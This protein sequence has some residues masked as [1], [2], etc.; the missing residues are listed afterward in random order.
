M[1]ERD[2]VVFAADGFDLICESDCVNELAVSRIA[3][4]PGESRR[5]SH[6]GI[7]IRTTSSPAEY[8][9]AASKISRPSPHGEFALLL[10]P[11]EFKGLVEQRGQGQEFP[12]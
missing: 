6:G 7:G 12:V 5:R 1:P 3:K 4:R 8:K 9:S 2:P 10:N 11:C